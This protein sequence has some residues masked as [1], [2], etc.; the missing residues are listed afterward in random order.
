[1]ARCNLDLHHPKF[2][3][4]QDQELELGLEKLRQTVAKDYKL[5]GWVNH[6]M[7]KYPLYQNKIWKWDFAP[8]GDRS[9]TR[10]GWRLYAYISDPRAAEP[11]PATAFLCYDKADT[12]SGDHTKF[13]AAAIKKFLAETIEVEA[14]DNPFRRQ[15][16][17]DGEII[18][19]CENCCELVLISPDESDIEIAERTHQCVV[20]DIAA[21]SE[22]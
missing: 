13:V 15:V 9:R 6:P 12:P 3:H 17:G 14:V 20:A 4:Y 10:K 5:S 7:P 8:E 18:S 16:N 19:L 21:A 1:L 22:E 11:I 2:R